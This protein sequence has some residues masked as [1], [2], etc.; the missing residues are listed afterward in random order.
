MQ[1]NERIACDSLGC[2]QRM[3]KLFLENQDWNGKQGHQDLDQ[4]WKVFCFKFLVHR[5]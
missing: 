5:T 4:E 3:W 2:C 1:R